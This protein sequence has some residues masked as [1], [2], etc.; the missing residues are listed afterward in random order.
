MRTFKEW[1]KKE[2]IIPKVE[3]RRVRNLKQ[4]LEAVRSDATKF[5]KTLRD[6]V[7]ELADEQGTFLYDDQVEREASNA[8]QKLLNWS[9]TTSEEFPENVATTWAVSLTNKFK[10]QTE[11]DAEKAQTGLNKSRQGVY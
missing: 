3:V 4:S 8:P 11:R 10:K 1:L 7:K 2:W 6:F 9:N 5:N